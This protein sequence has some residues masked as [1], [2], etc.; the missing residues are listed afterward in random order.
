[1]R[2]FYFQLLDKVVEEVG[3]EHVVQIVTDNEAA[4]KS[5]GKKLMLK[6]RHLY[7]SS[8]AAH[9][10]DLCLEDIAKRKTV[11]AVLGDAKSV[12]NFIYNHIWTVSLMK[13]YTGGRE[14]VRPGITRFATQF[15]QLQAI[16][17]QKEGLINMFNS[18][19][20]RRSKFGR[21]KSG[22]AF[23]A[24][25]IVSNKDFGTKANDILKVFEPLIRV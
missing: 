24:L 18:Q 17:K 4:L 21:D 19:E 15:L 14:I 25:K 12:T 3:E 6:R 22:P 11:S 23:D 1:M 13:K 8:C 10:L 7:W 2:I 16:V 5:A 20:F 9:C